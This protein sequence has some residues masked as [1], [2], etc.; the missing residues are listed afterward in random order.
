M[1]NYSQKLSAIERTLVPDAGSLGSD[2]P[3]MNTLLDQRL[4]QRIWAEYLEMPGMKLT[5]EQVQRLCGIE[6]PV[7]K[8]ML[9]SL[10]QAQFLSQ[11]PDGSYVRMTEGKTSARRAAKAELKLLPAMTI[12]RRAS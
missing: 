2:F 9:D 12:S 1:G 10:V 6:A 5:M 7:C 4:I 3:A 11:K 8:A